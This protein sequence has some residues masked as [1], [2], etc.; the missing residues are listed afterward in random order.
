MEW[1]P[2]SFFFPTTGAPFR[3]SLLIKCPTPR[4]SHRNQRRS[5]YS[6]APHRPPP[7]CLRGA[8]VCSRGPAA[9]KRTR[10]LKAATAV[11]ETLAAWLDFVPQKSFAGLAVGRA[12][13][14][15][16]RRV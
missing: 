10:L 2:R 1:R 12:G 7:L 15:P 5:R 3:D 8:P 16:D 4:C 11:A 14:G 6:S 13:S 9:P